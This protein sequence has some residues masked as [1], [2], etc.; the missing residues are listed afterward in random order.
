VSASA[1][2]R[3]AQTSAQ[4][5]SNSRRIHATGLTKRYGMRTVLRSIDVSV[6]AGES[7]VIFGPNGAGK[8]T[9]LR[10]LSTLTRSAG[11]SLQI[12]GIDADEDPTSVRAQIGVLAHQPYVYDS[13]TARENLQF[14]ARMYEVDNPS[15]RIEIALRSVD[16]GERGDDRVGTFSRGM[17]QR[18]ALARAIL[19]EPSILLL[20]EPDTGLDPASVRMLEGILDHHCSGGGAA[21]FTTHD[22]HFGLR[23]AERVLVMVSGRVVVDR[24]SSEIDP[25]EIE[26]VMGA[27][28]A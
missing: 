2:D 28:G 3:D 15:E 6:D 20:D 18:I 13:L 16:L 1:T 25:S 24:P 14:F 12:N 23:T 11:G 17:L 5:V 22:L 10:I 27:P 9:L 4:S 19:H 7:V 21:L 26:A 8:T